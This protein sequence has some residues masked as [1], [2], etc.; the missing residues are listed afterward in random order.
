[1]IDNVLL[2]NTLLTSTG[3]MSCTQKGVTMRSTKMF[4]ILI[5][6]LLKLTLRDGL[7]A[8]EQAQNPSSVVQ[9]A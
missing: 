3:R 2:V 5:S 7:S 6:D 1:V 4:V 8:P 9:S